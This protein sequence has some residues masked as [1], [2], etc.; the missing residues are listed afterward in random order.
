MLS[1]QPRPLSLSAAAAQHSGVVVPWSPTRRELLRASG[2]G[3]TVTVGGCLG[4]EGSDTPSDETPTADFPVHEGSVPAPVPAGR[5]CDGI[6]GMESAGFPEW[7]AQ[8]AHG[9]GTGA[10]FCSPG[11]LLAYL[12]ATEH[13][14]GNDAPVEEIW[15]RDYGSKSLIDGKSAIFVI[16]ADEGEQERGEPMGVNPRPFTDEPAAIAY[17]DDREWLSERAILPFDAIDYEIAY[18]YNAGRIPSP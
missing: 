18:Q 15:V 14:G 1:T 8:L 9:D 5:Q 3:A 13:V 16:E 7:N 2:V 10:F 6:C 17:V 12:F 11:G 4:T